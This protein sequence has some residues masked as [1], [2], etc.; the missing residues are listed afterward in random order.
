MARQANKS[1][2]HRVSRLHLVHHVCSHFTIC[3]PTCRSRQDIHYDGR[4]SRWA[5][6]GPPTEG[7]PLDVVHMYRRWGAGLLGRQSQRAHPEV[8]P[9]MGALLACSVVPPHGPWQ[10]DAAD[11]RYSCGGA[12]THRLRRASFVRGGVHGKSA[13]RRAVPRGHADMRVGWVC[14]CQDLI[15]PRAKE[16]VIQQDSN[17]GLWVMNATEASH[18]YV[19]SS[20]YAWF[21]GSQMPLHG[22][23]VSLG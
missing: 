22:P 7:L 18:F 14:T 20:V 3:A 2:E 6:C 12:T 15:T 13:G 16:L 8:R 1:A 21:C 17:M 9:A 19:C 5:R 23:S 10:N 4:R 11:L